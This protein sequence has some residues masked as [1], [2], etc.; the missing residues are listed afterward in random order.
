MRGA[1][2]IPQLW[3]SSAPVALK[4]RL[5][6]TGNNGRNLWDCLEGAPYGKDQLLGTLQPLKNCLDL[7]LDILCYNA[8]YQLF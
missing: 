8:K 6:H 1:R 5:C 7:Q 4:N 2:G 3:V